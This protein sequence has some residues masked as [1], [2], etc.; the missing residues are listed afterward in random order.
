MKVDSPI[1]YLIKDFVD[2]KIVLYWA[3]EAGRVVSPMFLN[4]KQA[5][6]W[7]LQYNFSLYRGVER[8]QSI[9]DR[10]KLHSQRTSEQRSRQ[11]PSANPDGR[12]Y[13]DIEIRI[14]RDLSR[15]K[16]LQFYSQNPH[17][18]EGD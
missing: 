14:D 1:L 3:D 15:V 11:I 8:R 4:L 5:E 17:L 13:T 7:W 10:R 2:Q 9:H 16:L 12:R 18:L 6:E